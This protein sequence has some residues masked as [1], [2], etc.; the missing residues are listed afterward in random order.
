MR[1]KG[2]VRKLQLKG[3]I[4]ISVVGPAGDLPSK[5]IQF[6]KQLNPQISRGLRPSSAGATAL[7]N[8]PFAV[9][10]RTQE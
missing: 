2:K 1:E 6:E 4:T 5:A 3:Y 9:S 7:Q 10:L 8:F